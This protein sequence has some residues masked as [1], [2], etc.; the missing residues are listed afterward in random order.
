M[1]VEA[2]HLKAGMVIERAPWS[3]WG[4][5]VEWETAL[6]S[7]PP[8]EVDPDGL[9]EVVFVGGPPPL[10]VASDWPIELATAEA[11]DLREVLMLGE[12]ERLRHPTRRLAP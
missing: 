2:Q 3:T 1:T 11:A 5:P 6:V 9:V 4:E 12:L 7:A 10:V 8:V